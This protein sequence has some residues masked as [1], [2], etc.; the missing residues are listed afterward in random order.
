ML[1]ATT[2][3]SVAILAMGGLYLASAAEPRQ[4]PFPKPQAPPLPGPGVDPQ[5][6]LFVI[7]AQT[8]DD[9]ARICDMC[10]IHCARM[11]S[12]GKKEHFQTLRLCQDCAEICSATARVAA[13]DGPLSDL[14]Y[15]ACADACKRCGDACEKFASDP[16]MNKCVQECRRCEKMC[17]DMGKPNAEKK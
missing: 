15:L 11:L 17:R 8:C 5:M 4:V 3:F 16:M 1:R 9:C 7:C 6:P 13:K 10:S 2:L 12:E 14:M